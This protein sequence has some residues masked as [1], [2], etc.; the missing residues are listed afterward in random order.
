MSVFWFIQ[1][2]TKL[3]LTIVEGVLV[4]QHLLQLSRRH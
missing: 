1:H 2:S 4:D 3:D